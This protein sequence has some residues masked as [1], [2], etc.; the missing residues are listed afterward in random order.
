MCWVSFREIFNRFFFIISFFSCFLA[1]S[2]SFKIGVFRLDLVING[3]FFWC[4]L[5]EVFMEIEILIVSIFI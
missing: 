3:D 4:F 5:G 2:E 1:V